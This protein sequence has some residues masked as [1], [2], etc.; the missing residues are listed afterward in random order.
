[1]LI[2]LQIDT[3]TL[4]GRGLGRHHGKAVFVPYSAPGDRVR[5]RV[6]RSR[7]QYDEAELVE[8]LQPAPQR[9]S[10]PCPVFG[11]CGGCQWQHLPYPEQ[12]RWKEQLF[13]EQLLRA[14]VA[15]ATACLPVVAAPGEWRYRNRLQYKCRQTPHGFVAGFYRHA[16]HF[17]IDAPHC[18]LAAPSI[19]STYTILREVLPASPCPEAIPQVDIACSDDGSV[20]VVVHVL[21]EAAA[22]LRDWLTALAERSSFAVALQAGRKA[23]LEALS[24][25]PSLMTVVDEPPLGLQIGAGGF[26]QVNPAQNRRLAAAVVAAAALTGGE[27]VLD[28]YCGV[29]NFTLPLARRAGSV[30]GIEGYPPAVADAR[31]NARRHTIT[32][33]AF[34]AEPA[35]GAAVHHGSFDLVV[36]D[37]PRGGAYPVMRDLLK[38][39]PPR[40]LYISC[41]PATLVR[42]LQPLVH[43][44]YSVVS[45]QPFDFFP[46]TWH[47]ESLTLLERLD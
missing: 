30:L 2:D 21:P 36:L 39:R 8:L 29:G 42:D 34:S 12:A 40:I 18:L 26:A 37:P 7:A 3:L 33:V 46:Q 11:R 5:C 23:T 14:G 31:D 4:G 6:T 16:S 1:M 17:V 35:E 15:D 45:S 44:G 22:G 28:L 13:T 41:D 19:D 24:G 47:I 27:R 43:H 20:A 9:R 25:A 38:L 32:N 10:P